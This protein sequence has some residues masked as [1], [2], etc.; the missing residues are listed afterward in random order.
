[1]CVSDMYG[2]PGYLVSIPA[3]LLARV[4][5]DDHMLWYDCAV[6]PCI[7]NMNCAVAAGDW[8]LVM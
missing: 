8:K 5:I 1:M 3:E 6:A 4:G 2:G 7:C